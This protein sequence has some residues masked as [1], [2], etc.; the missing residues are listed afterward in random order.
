[1]DWIHQTFF[2]GQGGKELMY[3]KSIFFVYIFRTKESIRKNLYF[4]FIV[5]LLYLYYNI[6]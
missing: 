2:F 1:M 4:K 6:V 3:F 5:N